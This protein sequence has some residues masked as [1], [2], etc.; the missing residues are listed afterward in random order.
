MLL[1][2]RMREKSCYV[3]SEDMREN[4]AHNECM[5][6]DLRQYMLFMKINADECENSMAQEILAIFDEALSYSMFDGINHKLQLRI[7]LECENSMRQEKFA[8]LNML[9]SYSMFED[10]RQYFLF[11]IVYA[12]FEV[13]R[14]NL[15]FMFC[16][17]CE[18]SMAKEIFA[19]LYESLSYSKFVN[20]RHN[21]RLYMSFMRE[22][23]EFEIMRHKIQ[24][25]FCTASEDSTGQ[26][27]FAILDALSSF[28]KFDCMRQNML[29]QQLIK[30]YADFEVMRHN[31]VHC[32]LLLQLMRR[33]AEC[34]NSRQYVLR[35]NAVL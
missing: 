26:K 5:R 35:K 28:S 34:E 13:M 14:Q 32:I 29:L 23:A 4:Y 6:Q 10:M 17:E 27:V 19:I 24:L 25:R 11:M 33:Y 7:C 30:T 12:D 21:L 31:D 22:N 20:M 3:I 16:P 18:N 2:L 1:M 8:A 15:R 9:L